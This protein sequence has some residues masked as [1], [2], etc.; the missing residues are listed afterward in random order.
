MYA[1]VAID[2]QTNNLKDVYDYIVPE[3]LIN[4]VGIGSRVKVDF[5]VRCVLG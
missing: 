4:Y 5:G 1:S 2:I 3:E